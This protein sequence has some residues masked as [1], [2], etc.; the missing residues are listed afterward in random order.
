MVCGRSRYLDGSEPKVKEVSLEPLT[1]Y[2]LTSPFVLGNDSRRN[3]T[4]R[5]TKAFDKGGSAARTIREHRDPRTAANI[6]NQPKI[7]PSPSVTSIDFRPLRQAALKRRRRKYSE[8]AVIN[9][10]SSRLNRFDW[11][12]LAI[13]IVVS[14]AVNLSVDT[15][16]GRLL[17]TLFKA[18][19]RATTKLLK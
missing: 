1:L 2:G 10:D 13:S 17:F 9:R 18:A 4:R 6:L 15:E 16:G 5:S 11:T 12:G 19:F 3:P 14:I 8:L 7:S